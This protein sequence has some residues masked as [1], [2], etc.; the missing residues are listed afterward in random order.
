MVRLALDDAKTEPALDSLYLSSEAVR[1]F[2]DKLAV[3]FTPYFPTLES[4]QYGSGVHEILDVA[5][6][7]YLRV[8]STREPGDQLAYFLHAGINAA[9]AVL[10]SY[11]ASQ[12]RDG[13][14]TEWSPW[15]DGALGKWVRWGA[16]PLTFRA[17]VAAT[18]EMR[19]AT[20]SMLMQRLLR[21][22]DA[23]TIARAGIDMSSLD[24]F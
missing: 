11:S 24:L 14:L 7:G 12:V 15:E 5:T 21:F 16:G 2:C 17:E 6:L 13:S 22:N 1:Q 10:L 9:T 20:R 19:Y 4:D 8:S 23:K 3:F 18:A